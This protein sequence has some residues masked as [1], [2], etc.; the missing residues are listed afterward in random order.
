M[1]DV[2][3]LASSRNPVVKR[4]VVDDDAVLHGLEKVGH[5]G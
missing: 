1:P 5:R 3:C 4:A 2:D